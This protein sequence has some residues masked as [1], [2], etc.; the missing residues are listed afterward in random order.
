M[1]IK[2]VA[3]IGLAL[4]MVCAA[5]VVAS[6]ATYH[7]CT[8]KKASTTGGVTNLALSGLPNQTTK[9]QWCTVAAASNDTALAVALTSIS[10]GMPVRIGLAADYRPNSTTFAGVCNLTQIGLEN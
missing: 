10:L 7:T 9:A 4:A 2:K 6:A 1:K 3:I 5:A 8:V